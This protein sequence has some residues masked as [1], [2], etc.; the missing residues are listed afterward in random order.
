MYLKA[1]VCSLQ[2]LRKL[3]VLKTLKKTRGF[4]FTC[5][6]NPQHCK[7]NKLSCTVKKKNTGTIT[8]GPKAKGSNK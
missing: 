3:F 6:L 2:C 5:M 8:G 4:K 1:S 7:I